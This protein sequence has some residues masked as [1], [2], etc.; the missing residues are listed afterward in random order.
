MKLAF[1]A[2][3]GAG[4]KVLVAAVMAGA[5]RH[6]DCVIYVPTYG[7][8]GVL[9]DADAAACYGVRASSRIILD[10]YRRAGKRTFFFDKGYWGRGTYTR[11]AVDAWH[12]HGSWLRD[13]D[14]AR[15]RTTGQELKP[16]RECAGQ[17][18]IYAGTT[19]TWCDL[20]DLGP[21][22][23]LDEVIVKL[24]VAQHPGRVV[25]RPRPAYARKHPELCGPI[26]GA[27][28]SDPAQPLAE[29][30]E[31]CEL[32][33]TLGSNSAVEARAA[34]VETLVLGDN[35]IQRLNGGRDQAARDDLFRRLAYCQWTLDEY[36][37]GEAWAD[38]KETMDRIAA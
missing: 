6:G 3:D 34:G 26:E 18:V 10:A 7:Y 9:A 30:L 29:A 17:N 2:P 28:L 20:Y 36:L 5:Q 19:Q 35:P 11:V 14:H 24:L 23:Q 37:S 12:T 16:M 22:R 21:A 15:L 13:R 4:D 8:E 38:L 1:Y 32:L 27:L 31:H 33:V 25:Y